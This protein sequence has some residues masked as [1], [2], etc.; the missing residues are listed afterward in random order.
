MCC[1]DAFYARAV[2]LEYAMNE[3]PSVASMTQEAAP[4]V[5]QIDVKPVNAKENR[6][7]Y[8]ARE[9]VYPKLV[10]GK[11]RR[12]KW[13]V[14]I[15]TLGIY[16]GLPWIRW[17][18]G[19]SLPDQAFLL[20]FAHQ[21]LYLFGLE[22]WAQEFYFVTGILIL[23]A[24]ALFLV[25]ALA[26]RVWCGYTCP[27][28]IWSD[29]MIAVERFWQ[30]D[31]NARMRL[32]KL[33]W[34]FGKAWR[35]AGTHFSWLLIGLLTGGAFVFYFR[36]A[37]TLLSRSGPALCAGCHDPKRKELRKKHLGADLATLDC[38]TCH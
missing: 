22:I 1:C 30:G 20:D 3:M 18:R 2:A 8:K 4:G 36:D 12:I 32:A 29:L 31:R 16:Y 37:P 14:M 24:L 6:S 19:P 11:F 26:G 5:P 21:R 7:L 28:T 38:S 15:V 23:S 10:H 33:P 34:S 35:I 25:T 9:P 27:Q 17:D 13:A